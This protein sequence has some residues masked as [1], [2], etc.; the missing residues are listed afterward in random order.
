MKPGPELDK[1]IGEKVM[2]GKRYL[3]NSIFN[4]DVSA[5]TLTIGKGFNYP[6]YSTDIAEAW[7]V[8][9]KLSQDNFMVST[10]TFTKQ[11]H[12]SMCLILKEAGVD[13]WVTA[14]GDD[15][16]HAICLAALKLLN[17]SY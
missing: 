17:I 5:R 1:L 13:T 4:V 16:P 6:E 12:Q 9:G 2:A 10:R 7:E 8:V 3:V 14:T 11:P 15:I